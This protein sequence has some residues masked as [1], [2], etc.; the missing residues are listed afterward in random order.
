MDA[1]QHLPAHDDAECRKLAISVVMTK[2]ALW[3]LQCIGCNFMEESESFHSGARQ[4][5]DRGELWEVRSEFAI[6][7]ACPAVIA[8]APY[9]HASEVTL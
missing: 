5:Q 3:K 6:L 8:D 4:Q 2:G 1:L 9:H 7:I